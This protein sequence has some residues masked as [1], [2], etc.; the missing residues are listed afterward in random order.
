MPRSHA[1][2]M[3]SYINVFNQK[4]MSRW[5]LRAMEEL[6]RYMRIIYQSVFETVEDI[7]REMIARGKHGRLQLTIDEVS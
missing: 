6:P 4:Q 2:M 1:F 7:D 3:L 5:D